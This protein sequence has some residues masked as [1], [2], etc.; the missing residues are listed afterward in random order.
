M[1]L[2][3]LLVSMVAALPERFSLTASEKVIHDLVVYI[4]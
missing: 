4:Y 3:A 2:E 1:T